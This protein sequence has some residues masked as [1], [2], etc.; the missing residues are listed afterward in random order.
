MFS[1]YPGYIWQYWCYCCT[2]LHFNGSTRGKRWVLLPCCHAGHQ[3]DGW[4]T[5]AQLFISTVLP[6]PTA[7]PT[8]TPSTQIKYN[9]GKGLRPEHNRDEGLKHSRHCELWRL[10][11]AVVYFQKTTTAQ[12]VES[13][14]RTYLRTAHVCLGATCVVRQ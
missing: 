5:L 6:L 14:D 2:S 10:P 7:A 8:A 9:G 13:W 12:S 4:N 3:T 11:I 1:P